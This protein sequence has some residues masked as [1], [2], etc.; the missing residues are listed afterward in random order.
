LVRLTGSSNNY[1]RGNSINTLG[2]IFDILD[3]LHGGNHLVIFY[4]EPEYAHIVEYHF[5]KTGLEKGESC[6][7]TTH[8]DDIDL[9][10][11]GLTDFGV[12]VEKYKKNNTL[13][14]YKISDSQTDSEGIRQGI[15][16]LRKKIMDNSKPPFRIVSRFTRNFENEMDRQAS[17]DVERTV[18]SSFEKYQSSFIC[19]YQVK[20]IKLEM[21]EAWMQNHLKNH[22]AAIFVFNGGEGL[23]FNLPA[24]LSL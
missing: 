7:Y 17:I 21:K 14:V 9:I 12:N 5:I 2:Q 10:E 4:E 24:N 6:I 20:N 16:K 3:N 22:H 13:H 11:R 1:M 15:E 18:H 19:P 8:E 23:A